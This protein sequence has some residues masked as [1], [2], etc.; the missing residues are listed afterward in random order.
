MAP[1][2]K[3]SLCVV[4]SEN[5]TPNSKGVRALPLEM[6]S[7]CGSLRERSFLLSPRRCFR[8]RSVRASSSSIRSRMLGRRTW[9][10]CLRMSAATHSVKPRSSF[11]ASFISLNLRPRPSLHVLP[12]MSLASLAYVRTGR[13]PLF[14]ASFSM[15]LRALS[16]SFPSNG[17]AMF[18]CIT[19]VSTTIA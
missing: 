2:T 5:L 3:H 10:S 1:T 4:T 12:R 15:R 7:T 13:M 8:S 6:Q 9:A 18:L 11:R 14:R 19:V 16:Q 17:K